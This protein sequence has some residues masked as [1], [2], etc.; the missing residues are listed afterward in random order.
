VEF[1]EGP[2]VFTKIKS[3]L[4]YKSEREANTSSALLLYISFLSMPPF[5]LLLSIS[6]NLSSYYNMSQHSA[7]N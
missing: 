7:L 6:I 1:E 5:I 3:G 2:L 4:E